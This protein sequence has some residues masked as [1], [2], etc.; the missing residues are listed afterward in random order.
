MCSRNIYFLESHKRKETFT[1]A[2]QLQFLAETNMFLPETAVSPTPRIPNRKP[3]QY[4]LCCIYWI[5]I[6]FFV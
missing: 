5:P 3:L 1:L 6:H 4:L 2:K